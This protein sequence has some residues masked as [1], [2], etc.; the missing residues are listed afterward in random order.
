M[1]YPIKL[2][3]ENSYV[4]SFLVLFAYSITDIKHN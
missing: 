1:N 2:K 3:M 4:T